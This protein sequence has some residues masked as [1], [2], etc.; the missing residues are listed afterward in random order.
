MYVGTRG[1]NVFRGVCPSVHKG[2]GGLGW[3]P[4]V[5]VLSGNEEGVPPVKLL[6]GGGSCPGP[7]WGREGYLLFRTCLAGPVQVL[8]GEGK[9]GVMWVS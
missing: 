6:S 2:D 9:E 7:V 4:P 3:V 1:G 5:Q 8:S